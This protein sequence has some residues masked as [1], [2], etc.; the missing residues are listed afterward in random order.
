MKTTQ[1]QKILDYINKWGSITSYQAFIDLGITQC[2]KQEQCSSC[3]LSDKE[4]CCSINE[5]I[6]SEW[7]KIKI[8][9]KINLD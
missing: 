8:I 2:S 6:P 5:I 7:T 1:R 9:K 3:P 4:E